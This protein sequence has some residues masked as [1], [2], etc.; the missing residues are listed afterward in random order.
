MR[1]D[2]IIIKDSE[3]RFT[4]SIEGEGLW[5]PDF[6]G[7]GSSKIAAFRD[8]EAKVFREG[9]RQLVQRRRPRHD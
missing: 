8:L 3:G 1:G 6:V 2:I 7:V 9:L 4:A 5:P